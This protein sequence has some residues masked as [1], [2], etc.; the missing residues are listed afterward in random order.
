MAGSTL[1]GP[2]TDKYGRKRMAGVGHVGLRRPTIWA[3][4]GHNHNE[5]VDFVLGLCQPCR[6]SGAAGDALWQ[7]TPIDMLWGMT[8]KPFS[9]PTGATTD[10]ILGDALLRPVGRSDSIEAG[11]AVARR[12]R[13]LRSAGRL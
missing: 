7:R 6:C 1:F 11:L 4:S 10:R 12:G 3:D 8:M 13:A 9:E 5:R 2:L